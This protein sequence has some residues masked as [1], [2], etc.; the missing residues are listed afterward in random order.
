MQYNAGPYQITEEYSYTQGGLMTGKRL[1]V[2]SGTLQPVNLDTYQTYD[3]EGKPVSVKYPTQTWVDSGTGQVVAYTTPTYTT[4][5]DAM[6][7]PISLTD[8]NPVNPA[9]WVNN[10][11]YGLSSELLQMNYGIANGYTS[12]S[13]PP[14]CGNLQQNGFYTGPG[15]T[16]P[17]CN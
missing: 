5:Y 9:T 16:I 1:A 8:N 6:G 11:Q 3:N 15:S 2:K 7:R 4:A 17:A 10:V 12:P 13:C 14:D